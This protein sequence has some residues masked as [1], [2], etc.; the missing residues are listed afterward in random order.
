MRALRALILFYSYY[1]I[2]NECFPY[3]IQ[4][5]IHVINPANISVVIF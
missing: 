5:D 1:I 2:I 4:G 3:L